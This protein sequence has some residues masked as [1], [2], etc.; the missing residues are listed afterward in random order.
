MPSIV[1]LA[2]VVDYQRQRNIWSKL[3]RGELKLEFEFEH[4]LYL[5][6]QRI[7]TAM[8]NDSLHSTEALGDILYLVEV[9]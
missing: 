1:A 8:K 6:I 9:H 7:S 5:L 3:E 2:V 4:A